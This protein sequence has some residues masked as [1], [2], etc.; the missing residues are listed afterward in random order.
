LPMQSSGCTRSSSKGSR[1]KPCCLPRTP[2]P[3]CSGRCLLPVRSTCA[4]SMV[5][6]P[7]PQSP[8]ISQLTSPPETIPSCYR[9]TRHTEFQPLAGPY[10]QRGVVSLI[11][12]FQVWVGPVEAF[13]ETIPAATENTAPLVPSI[14]GIKNSSGEIKMS[15]HRR[16]VFSAD[17]HCVREHYISTDFAGYSISQIFHFASS[18]GESPKIV[19]TVR[20]QRPD[21]PPARDKLGEY[22]TLYYGGFCTPDIYKYVE[23]F[24]LVVFHPNIPQ[25]YLWAVCLNKF[26]A[27]EP[28][29]KNSANSQSDSSDRQNNRD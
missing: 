14:V 20:P 10:L 16:F 21:K 1:R 4:K 28:N 2:R 17:P 6:R 13:A 12:I 15:D 27:G 24:L 25:D 9:R 22:P 7:S 8:S 18:E 26:G 23:N 5:G 3:C 29:L 11:C 19:V